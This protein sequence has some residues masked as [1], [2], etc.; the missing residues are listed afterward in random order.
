MGKIY[1]VVGKSA[2]GKDTIFKAI[3][4]KYNEIIPILNYTTRP[5]R[6]GEKEGV[7]YHFV[8][9]EQ[10]LSYEKQ[11]KVLECRKYDTVYGEWAYFTL[12]F[13]FEEDKDYIILTT[14]EGAKAIQSKYGKDNICLIYI[15]AHAKT[16]LLRSIN[17]ISKVYGTEY[18]EM[19]RRFLTDEKDY[20]FNKL[21][22][23]KNYSVIDNNN[24]LEEALVQWEKIYNNRKNNKK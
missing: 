9:Y 8:S 4:E 16:R 3:R 23:F 13:K 7:E 22:H 18:T 11:N 19:C 15:Q 1:C 2:S 17:R 24:T 6:K 12:D 10:Y 21:Y 14:I 20:S 5:K